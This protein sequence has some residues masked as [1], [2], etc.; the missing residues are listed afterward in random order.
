MWF[1]EKRGGE[2]DILLW[3]RDI[4]VCSFSGREFV[5]FGKGYASWGI[6]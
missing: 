5:K 2:K 6:C 4:N 3:I 1:L